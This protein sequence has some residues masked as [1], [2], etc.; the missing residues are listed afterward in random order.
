MDVREYNLRELR[1]AMTPG[2]PRRAMPAIDPRTDHVI[3]DVGCGAGQTL[4]A[5]QLPPETVRVGIDV[6]SSGFSLGRDLDPAILFVGG[7]GESLPFRDGSFDLV[8]VRVALP[9][10]RTRPALAELC[11]VLRPG[12]TIWMTLHHVSFVAQAFGHDLA[13][14]DVR[15]A[16]FRLYVLTNGLI[17]R[18][19]GV[20]FACPFTMGRVETFQTRGGMKKRLR[21]LGCDDIRMEV[22][23]SVFVVTARKRG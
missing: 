6:D 13:R 4:I 14:L 20:E 18:F 5:S 2:D 16:M 12:G 7:R 3:L 11:R 19:F 10:M 21:A 9:Y 15:R 8:I 17:S 22:A 23:R 1:I